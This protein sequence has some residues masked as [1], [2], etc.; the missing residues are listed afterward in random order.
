MTATNS[1]S[2]LAETKCSKSILPVR[3]IIAVMGML[4]GVMM[5]AIRMNLSVSILAMV[6]ETAVMGQSFGNSSD[7]DTYDIDGIPLHK[8]GTFLW[9]PS[10]QGLILGAYFYGYSITQPFTGYLA[11]K[12]DAAKLVTYGMFV[13]SILTFISPWAAQVDAYLFIL[14]RLLIGVF[15]G[16]YFTCIYVMYIRWTTRTERAS[17]LGATQIGA[18]LGVCL[19]LPLTAYLCEF[20]FSGGYPSAFYVTGVLTLIWTALWHVYV[21]S[22]PDT[23]KCISASELDHIK[24]NTALVCDD[25]KHSA[26]AFGYMVIQTKLPAYLND[27]HNVPIHINGYI[28]SAIYVSVC[29][30]MGISGPL[31]GYMYRK[32]VMSLIN[33][34]KLFQA[35]G[36]S[37][38]RY[39]G[40]LLTIQP[41]NVVPA[42]CLALIP[43]VGTN[44]TVVYCLLIGSMFGFGFTCGGENPIVG[45]FAPAYAGHIF[46]IANTMAAATGILAPFIVG[47]LL[48]ATTKQMAW[49][50]TFYLSSAFFLFGAIFFCIFATV[51]QQSWAIP[52]AKKNNSN[53]SNNA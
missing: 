25:E 35:I 47:Y 33:I 46:G 28:N 53:V 48:E 4:G 23:H 24:A 8:R 20:G 38:V 1:S 29:L 30:S 44:S 36:E 22:T 39:T 18:N 13:S 5:F 45:E 2:H 41:A 17:A 19:T 21:T 37:T 9:S 32:G 12:F 26:Q 49:F 42:I 10:T 16:P 15:Q 52:N 27:V 50:I 14:V 7:T 34:R 51:E 43:L 40:F 11:E 3:L 6:N 31:S